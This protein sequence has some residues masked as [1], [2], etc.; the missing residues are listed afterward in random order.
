MIH[1]DPRRG[2][3]GRTRCSTNDKGQAYWARPGSALGQPPL[4][5][6]E[7]FVHVDGAALGEEK[8]TCT[9]VNGPGRRGVANYEPRN[10]LGL[11]AIHRPMAGSQRSTAQAEGVANRELRVVCSTSSRT[12][13]SHRRRPLLIR[14][15][16]RTRP[17]WRFHRESASGRSRQ[18]ATSPVS[19][20]YR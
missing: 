20:E 16:R 8:Q 7:R 15:K 4:H 13:G 10:A 5:S 3:T 11:F 6:P 1:P 18:R 9:P 14:E 12:Q 19:P 2:H 17:L